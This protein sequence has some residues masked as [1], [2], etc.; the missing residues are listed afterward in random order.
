MA[1]IPAGPNNNQAPSRISSIG[2]IALLLT[3]WA[4]AFASALAQIRKVSKP[5]IVLGLS[6]SVIAIFSAVKAFIALARES[7]R[8]E[9]IKATTPPKITHPEGNGVQNTNNIDNAWQSRVGSSTERTLAND[10]KGREAI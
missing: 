8:N 3:S 7:R 9:T 4:T 10:N 6:A 2:W 5:I 1:D